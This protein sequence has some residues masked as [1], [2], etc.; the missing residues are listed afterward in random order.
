M[1]VTDIT[2]ANVCPRTRAKR[3]AKS[4]VV[5]LIG[6]P[7]LGVFQQCRLILTKVDVYLKIILAANNF[8]IKPAASQQGGAGQ[9]NY[10]ALI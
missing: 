10:K 7:D 1:N 2:G 8:V 9:Q 5:K 6:R 4:N 3:F